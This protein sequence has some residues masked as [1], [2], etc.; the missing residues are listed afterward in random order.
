MRDIVARLQEQGVLLTLT[1]EAKDWLAHEGYDRQFGA[2]PLKRTLQRLVESP[3]SLKLL[4]GE[5]SRGMTVTVDV[6]VAELIG[7]ER[8][9]PMAC[10]SLGRRGAKK[11]GGWP[12]PVIP[13]GSLIR[14]RP[15]RRS[16]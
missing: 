11:T 10:R 3:L 6:T 12:P 1:E 7:S 2:R 5:I 13:A 8:C 15:D 4:K 14:P 9:E 16:G